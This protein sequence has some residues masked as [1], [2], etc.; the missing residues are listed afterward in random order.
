MRRLHLLGFGDCE[1]FLLFSDGY[2]MNLARGR[3]EDGGHRE[4]TPRN[5]E[6]VI[7]A[8]DKAFQI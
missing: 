5:S 1:P 3:E 7:I 8:L 2:R 6:L 4:K